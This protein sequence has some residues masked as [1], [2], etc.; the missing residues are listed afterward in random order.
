MGKAE[1]EEKAV[2]KYDKSRLEANVRLGMRGVDSMDILPPQILLTQK[3]S[4][5]SQFV[6]KDGVQAKV[7]QYFHTGKSEIY[8]SF[9]CH[10]LFA[11]KGT[12]ISKQKPEEGKK[13]QYKVLGVLADDLSLFAQ[14]FRSSALFAL[15]K[16]FTAVISQK[17]PMF[18]FLCRMETKEL[19]GDK[20][21][22]FVPVLR[23]KGEVEDPAK[24][25]FLEEQAKAVDLRSEVEDEDAAIQAKS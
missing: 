6:D 11:A 25:V 15:S 24:L 1:A 23:L 14:V 17:R 8:D 5:F 3:L 12:Y 22:W 19:S 21:D 7:G 20:G 2:V 16:L 18:S 10:F 4:D 9:E 13:F